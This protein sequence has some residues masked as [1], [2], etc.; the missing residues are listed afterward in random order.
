MRI[1]SCNFLHEQEQHSTISRNWENRREFLSEV[2]LK[3]KPDIIC[4]QE[5]SWEQRKYMQSKLGEEC[6]GAYGLECCSSF[7][8]PV[9][10]IFFDKRQF[11]LVTAG[12]YW[13]SKTPHIF[14]SKSWDNVPRVANY[15]VLRGTN[16]CFRVLN[17]H[18]APG[19]SIIRENEVKVILDE[20]TAWSDMPQ[21]ITGDTNAKRSHLAMKSFFEAGWRDS[22]Y[23]AT[24][25]E[26]PGITHHNFEGEAFKGNV[27]GKLDWILIN[28]SF[29]ATNAEIIK[30]HKGDIY[31][32][33]HFP[34]SA[35]LLYKKA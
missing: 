34:I 2:I 5:V 27:G 4:C 29:E 33:D 12:G 23:E 25:I 21:I 15:V 26:E 11:E 9:N 16:G 8:H 35:D 14:G 24:G 22:F 1:I 7:R 10:T 6:F 17:M 31:P 30:D 32:S 3:R 28:E 20:C 13:L 18:L 19:P